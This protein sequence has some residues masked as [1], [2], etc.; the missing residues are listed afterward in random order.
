MLQIGIAAPLASLVQIIIQLIYY[1]TGRWSRAVVQMENRDMTTPE[2]VLT[3]LL[4]VHQSGFLCRHGR[5]QAPGA[6]GGMAH[7]GAHFVPV[8][9]C[10]RQCGRHRRNV[11]LSPQDPPLVFCDRNAC[12]PDLAAGGGGAGS[13]QVVKDAF[14]VRK[15]RER[16]EKLDTLFLILHKQCKVCCI[17]SLC[18]FLVLPPG[19]NGLVGGADDAVAVDQFLQPVGAPAGDAGDGKQGVNSSSGMP[20][21]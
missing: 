12:Y 8:G 15:T 16:V 9:H 7:P 18:N 13:I 2:L 20:S 1:R 5:G 11:C 17:L 10:G 21:I 14:S 19:Q 4:G 6:A 3:I